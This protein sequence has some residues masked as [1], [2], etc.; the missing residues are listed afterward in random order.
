VIT[1]TKVGEYD[2]ICTELCGLGHS[3][4]RTSAIVMSQE[5]YDAWLKEQPEGEGQG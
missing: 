1:P 4:M 2:V 3:V 5:D